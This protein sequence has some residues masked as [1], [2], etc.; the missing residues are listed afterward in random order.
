MR[1]SENGGC[2]DDGNGG[3]GIVSGQ[4]TGQRKRDYMQ[5]LYAL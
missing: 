3:V 1:T 5:I 4:W 2:G